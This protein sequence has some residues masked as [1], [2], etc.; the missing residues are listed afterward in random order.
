MLKL[1]KRN[2]IL[3]DMGYHEGNVLVGTFHYGLTKL[4]E[5]KKKKNMAFDK[6]CM[7]KQGHQETLWPSCNFLT[8][9]NGHFLSRRVF[10][11]LLN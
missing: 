7:P 1:A 10:L 5:N 3:I 2:I 4:V 8:G 9:W 11:K 6:V